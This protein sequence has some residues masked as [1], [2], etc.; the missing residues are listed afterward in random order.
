[1]APKRKQNIFVTA[2]LAFTASFGG[3]GCLLTGMRLEA[4]VFWLAVGC[5]VL[6]LLFALCLQRPKLTILPFCVIALVLGLWWE[7]FRYSVEGMIYAIS[8]LY[9]Q[10]YGWGVVQWSEWHLL[11]TDA[12]L[13]L[14]VAALP[15]V[16]AVSITTVKGQLGL[17][18]S[19]VAMLPLVVCVVLKD[20]VPAVGYLGV[21]FF[22]VI[23]ILLTENVR[24]RQGGQA[25]RLVK[26]LALP[27]AAVLVLLFL[28]SPPATY[29]GQ[30]GAQ[31]LED[32]ILALLEQEEPPELF[33]KPDYQNGDQEK[34]VQL[35]RVGKREESSE[36]V[37]T[38]KGQDRSLLY[39][40]GCAYDVYDG[41][42][43]S[44]TPGWN[45]WSLYYNSSGTEMKTI[46]VR[47][48]EPHSVL[49]FTYTPF[50]AENRV[51][52]GRMRNEEELTYYTVRYRDPIAYD[53]SLDEKYDDIGG[54]QLVE[55]LQLP[56]STR[57]EA[58]K[59]LR[60]RVGIPTETNNAGQVWRNARQIAKWVSDRGKY[61]LNAPTMPVTQGDF[62]LW[63]IEKGR[64]GYC[65]HFATAATVLLRAAGIPAQYVTGYLVDLRGG[66]EARVTQKQAHAWVEVFINGVGWVVL[67]ST[68]GYGSNPQQGH[69]YGETI[70]SE[71]YTTEPEQTGS[72]EPEQTVLTTEST[73]HTSGTESDGTGTQATQ[74]GQIPDGSHNTG[75]AGVG[76][77][78]G[79]QRNNSLLTALLWLLLVV[80]LLLG[81]IV[82]WRV[83]VSARHNS[84][85]HG[86]PNLCARR[87]WQ[88]LERMAKL[89]KTQPS[90][91]SLQVAQKAVFSQH[92]VSREEL[93]V[94]GAELT[95]LTTRLKQQNLLRRFVYTIIFALY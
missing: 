30:E 12:T 74:P 6:S 68:P 11:D 55:Y 41:K 24:S 59:I 3:V 35:D 72:T 82:Q 81:A 7:E 13:A 21:L 92:T 40:R 86:D 91:A 23:M 33:D 8:D 77:A 29:N 47:T 5:G 58:E 38:V 75:I 42:S 25:D 46:T 16:I 22:A 70:F 31:K 26:L 53:P 84:M 60:T 93:K 49:Y 9:D 62:A 4:S 85:T 87:R 17:L 69:M 61:D 39:L 1:M 89:L 78:D 94:M 2:L 44:S 67:E 37:M 66:E 88:T 79:G 52:G 50:D 65:T 32:F 80:A 43:W 20:T 51:L 10:G 64:T 90:E 34:V 54:A 63:F 36:L 56:D 15:T 76:G 14:L 19:G 83:R 57:A 45:S 48:V 28:I 18:G 27:L 71:G 73:E 95:A